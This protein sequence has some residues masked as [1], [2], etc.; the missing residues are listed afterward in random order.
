MRAHPAHPPAYGPVLK[1]RLKPFHF[2]G[3]LQ[4]T[5]TAQLYRRNNVDGK[6]QGHPCVEKIYRTLLV[7]SKI[8]LVIIE[9]VAH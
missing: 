1:H 8:A 9:N 7:I 4:M 3:A 5:S 6:L 2:A